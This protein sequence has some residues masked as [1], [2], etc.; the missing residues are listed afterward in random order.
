MLGSTSGNAFCP[1]RLETPL[2]AL[3]LLEHTCGGYILSAVTRRLGMGKAMDMM[4]IFGSRTVNDLAASATSNVCH[5]S[6]MLP[7][8]GKEPFEN[9]I[10]LHGIDCLTFHAELYF[11]ASAVSPDR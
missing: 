2:E 6:P 7:S 8:M 9:I 11:A 10:L 1:S 4:G 5:L 3:C